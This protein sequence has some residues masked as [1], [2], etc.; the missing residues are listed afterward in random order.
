MFIP[1]VFAVISSFVA[2]ESNDSIKTYRVNVKV[3]GGRINEDIIVDSKEN[4]MTVNLGDVSHLNNSFCPS[5][6]LH[7][8]E[9]KKVAIK[10]ID[11]GICMIVDTKEYYSDSVE[12]LN[13]ITM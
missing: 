9:M 8:F 2:V 11:Y 12:M 13:K 10:N 1:I 4:T 3:P 6:N 7:D 5:I